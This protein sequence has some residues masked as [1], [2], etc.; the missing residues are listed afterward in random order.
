M[1]VA[2]PIVD[3]PSLIAALAWR[4]REMRIRASI[5]E[6][7]QAAA[8][9]STQKQWERDDLCKILLPVFCKRPE[10]RHLV[11]AALDEMLREP[12]PV[13]VTPTGGK[14][15]LAKLATPPSSAVDESRGW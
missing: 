4:L 8:V 9:L 1:P 2:N 6:I 3:S 10:Q 5:S 12:E 7:E 11:E 14:D 15:E 13:E